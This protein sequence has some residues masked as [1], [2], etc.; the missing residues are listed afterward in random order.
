MTKDVYVYLPCVQRPSGGI[1]VL[2][3]FINALLNY[4]NDNFFAE[5]EDTPS[6]DCF[7]VHVIYEPVHNTES[8]FHVDMDLSWY[9]GNTKF[10][11]YPQLPYNSET[12]SMPSYCMCAD[13]TR[14]NTK[15][16]PAFKETDIFIVPEGYPNIMEIMKNV[17]CNKIVFCQS[18][19]Y[20]LNSLNNGA[21]WSDYGFTRCITTSN[22]ITNYIGRLWPEIEIRQYPVGINKALF[23]EQGHKENLI[24]YSCRRDEMNRIKTLTAIDYF[25]R[26]HKTDYQVLELDNLTRHEYAEAMRLAKFAL[27]TDDVAGLG[28]FPLEAMACGTHVIGWKTPGGSSYQNVHSGYWADCGDVLGLVKCIEQAIQDDL[29]GANKHLNKI[30]EC[31]VKE[32]TVVKEMDAIEKWN[33]DFLYGPIS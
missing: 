29:T 24:V 16:V 10:N 19:L 3:D 26:T 28:T 15:V 14:V 30:N 25:M 32:H 1:V 20:V 5:V 22:M 11:F 4:D 27:F 21:K 18:W 7:H 13:G 12:K 23:Y 6:I 33:K 9:E 17:V 31:I 2:L 8:G